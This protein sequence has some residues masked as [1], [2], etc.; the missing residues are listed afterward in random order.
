[1]PNSLPDLNLPSFTHQIT[2][3]A[4]RN[5]IFDTIRKKHVVLTPE[6]WVRQHF[7]HYLTDHLNYPKALISIEGALRVNGR[8]KRADII[9]FGRDGSPFL[10]VECKSYDIKLGPAT[11]QQS[12][13]YNYTLQAPYLVITNGRQHY[14][15]H[16]NRQQ[17]TFEFQ[18]G[19]P[20]YPG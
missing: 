17:Q 4:S 12:S 20:E 5:F 11:F 14:C 13:L 18:S 9:V 8:K 16:I 15:C 7:A 6:E 3:N 19:L 10:V 1:M 2:R